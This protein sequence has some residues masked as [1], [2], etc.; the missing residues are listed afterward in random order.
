MS[1]VGI[2]WF[3]P[4]KGSVNVI[5]QKLQAELDELESELRIHLPKEIKRALEFAMVSSVSALAAV[6]N[7]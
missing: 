1:K 2:A 7:C 3:D 5:K 6:L 4:L